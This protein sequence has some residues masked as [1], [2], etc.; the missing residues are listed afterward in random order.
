MKHY[1]GC[2]LLALVGAA[3]AHEYRI[4]SLLI[5]H[6]FA[7]ATPPGARVGGA[8]FTIENRGPSADKLMRATSPAAAS[9]E[10]HSMAMDGN[11]MRMHAVGALEVP[12]KSTV[13][14]RPGGLHVML[15]DLKQPL[16]PGD[17]VPLTLTFEK[18][19]PVDVEVQVESMTSTGNERSR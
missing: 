15:F 9:A 10:I 17:V 5:D 16:K 13:T 14:L 1:L 3:G 4:D 2:C 6:P 12:A 19:G 8:F 7:R 11:V 18:A